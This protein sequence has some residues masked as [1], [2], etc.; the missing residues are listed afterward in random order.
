MERDFT[1][2][3][4]CSIVLELEQVI[5]WYRNKGMSWDLTASSAGLTP[6]HC[7]SAV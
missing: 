3:A 6:N 1:I 5:D 4:N 7:S 2:N